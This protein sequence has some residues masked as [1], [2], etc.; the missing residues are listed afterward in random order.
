MCT[1]TLD[2]RGGREEGGREG[3]G[4]GEGGGR[5][6]EIKFSLRLSWVQNSCKNVRISVLGPP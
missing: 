1:C 4:E 6:R 2:S 5:E 3:E